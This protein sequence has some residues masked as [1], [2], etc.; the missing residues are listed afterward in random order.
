MDK[1]RVEWKT[2]ALLGACYA[3]WALGTTWLFAL[4]AP[5]G[6][7]ITVV[8][9]GLHSSLTHEMVHGHPFRSEIANEAIML[10]CLGLFVPFRRF[11]DLHLAHHVDSR[12]TDPYD[13]P[14]S[15]FQDPAVWV[16]LPRWVQVMLRVHNT[17]AG[18]M[19]L[20]PALGVYSLVRDDLRLIRQGDGAVRLA[21]LLHLP[22]VA[23]VL[24]W[25]VL[26]PIPFWAYLIAAYM[27]WSL[28]KIRTFLEHRAHER[29]SGR[30]VVIEDTGFFALLFLNNNY[31]VVHHMHP[32]VA[33]YDLP[34]MFRNNREKYL[35]RNDGYYY[36]SYAEIFRKHF[37]R[38]KD[39]VPHPLM[40]EG[41][42]P[43][44]AEVKIPAE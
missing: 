30:T 42:L 13:D 28:I 36:R 22:G 17:L 19:L 3:L 26:S 10:P 5:L 38:A 41:P 8:M 9:I 24:A 25:V 14:E 2:L 23:L 35:S 33:W 39:P 29:A 11:R 4:W 1:S 21:W 20:G 32:K 34:R 43:E 15:N 7:V 16:L 12:L 44:N 40:A 27:A 37:L 18:R 6:F 31:H